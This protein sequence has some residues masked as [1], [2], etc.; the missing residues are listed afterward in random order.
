MGKVIIGIHGLANK[1]EK[2]DLEKYWKTSI[3]EGLR[4]N[5]TDHTHLNF[6]LVYWSGFLYKN[7]MHRED[8]YEFDALYNTEPYFEAKKGAIQEHDDNW[9]DNVRKYA[10]SI[11][12]A[13]TDWLKNTFD[14]DGGANYVLKK[15]LKDLDYYYQNRPVRNND[16]IIMGAKQV[17]Q[18]ELEVALEKNQ[19]NEIM[20]IAHSMG[21][22]I[23][24]D[25]LRNL[26]KDR[27]DIAIQHFVTIGSPLGLPH[28]KEQ[29]V[30]EREKLGYEDAD[31]VRT[32][33]IV[34]NSWVN[35]ADPLDPVALDSHLNDDYLP[36][37]KGISIKDDIVE[38]DY[39]DN[40]GKRNHHK[41]YG[42]LRTPEL[43]RQIHA[44]LES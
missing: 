36:N 1:P 12:G 3:L 16:N 23:A 9:K 21:T 17:L 30:S 40:E 29:V 31:N 41:S 7:P 35:Y 33:S 28:V 37:A 5:G 27:N 19:G 43:S 20:L 38:N 15:K 14:F 4:H 2:A 13:G 25:V 8:G 44:F 11:F 42:Y 34:T 24:Y 39:S 18:N 6:Q 26:G 32:P 10:G 22:I